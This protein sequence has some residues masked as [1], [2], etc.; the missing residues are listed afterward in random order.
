MMDPSRFLFLF[1]YLSGSLSAQPTIEWQKSLGG[2][3]TDQAEAIC[4]LPDGGFL[5]AGNT[6]STDGDVFGNHGGTDIWLVNLS[7]IGNVQW[8]KAYGGSGN[9]DVYSIQQTRDLGYIM[10]GTTL[11]NNWDVSGNHG[12][13]D[14]WVVKLDSIGAIQWQKCFGG[15]GWE[16]AKSI[17]QTKDGGYVF[18][19][20]AT[21]ADGDVTQNQ[22]SFDLWVVKLDSAGNIEWQK[23]Y[24]GS[25]EDMGNSISQTLDDG[26]IL[27]GQSES[28]NGNVTGNHG[29]LDYWVLKLNYEGKIEW[30][31]SYGGPSIDRAVDIHQT[32]DDGYIV[33]G[34][35]YSM[36][37][38]V[39][40]NHGLNDFWVVKLT[41]AGGLV[42]QHS[43]GGSNEDYATS[44]YQTNDGA[45]VITG[46]TQSN[47]GDVFG[48]DGGA[49]L[50]VVKIGELGELKWE[51]TYGGSMAEWGSSIQQ[52][53]DGGF[54]IAGQAK[55]NNGDV[56]EAFGKDD[57][58]VI[59]L[60]PESSPLTSPISTPL[61]IYPNPTQN[62]ITLKLPTQEPD[63]FISITDLLGRELRNQTVATSQ[64][65][66]A[67][68]DLGTLPKG[69]YM[70]AATTTS[71]QVFLGKVLKEE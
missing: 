16:E 17:K 33:L 63:I 56:L 46:Q 1:C 61:T 58:W 38:D 60:S 42:W 40:G 45:Y 9:D 2:S 64:D 3:N 37:G 34:Q 57:Y 66:T 51:R 53:N 68:M 71:G 69:L 8:K 50:W 31:K 49:D 41:P 27:S 44:I 22:G 4:S 25:G 21:S 12:N 55:S 62:T 30:Q 7:S 18:T 54:I 70:V 28:I 65:G 35:S 36:S 67:K 52:T 24:G 29:S 11:S 47:N 48:N 6:R 23:P 15:T 32:I 14:A 10:S 20:F 59:K 5:V 13:Y 19:G 43:I 39:S 26:Y